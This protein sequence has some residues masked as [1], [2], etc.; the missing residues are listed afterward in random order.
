M[1]QTEKVQRA[2][3]ANYEECIGDI[4]EQFVQ[5][6]G[7]REYCNFLQTELNK[8]VNELDEIKKLGF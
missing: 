8:L 1:K 7:D 2:R 6:D 3:I 4:E 5:F